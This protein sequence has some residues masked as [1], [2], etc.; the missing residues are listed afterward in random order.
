MHV[1]TSAAFCTFF[2]I[3]PS[4]LGNIFNSNMKLRAAGFTEKEFKPETFGDDVELILVFYIWVK[5]EQK[6]VSLFSSPVRLLIRAVGSRSRR[7]D[8]L[9]RCGPS[10]WQQWIKLWIIFSLLWNC[11][12][13]LEAQ[14]CVFVCDDRERGSEEN[15]LKH[16]IQN[17]GSRAYSPPRG[18]ASSVRL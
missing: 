12:Q 4:S 6:W 7:H 15:Q 10:P 17:G 18:D 5:F 16:E 13:G 3:P 11:S 8:L 9:Q 14:M 1:L 2:I